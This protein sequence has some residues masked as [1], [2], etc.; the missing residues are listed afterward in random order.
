MFG[1]FLTLD[2]RHQKMFL[3]VGPKRAG[4]GVIAGVLKELVGPE[5]FV[6][7]TL[8]AFGSPFGLE[9]LTKASVACISDARLSSRSDLGQVTENLL[10]I[11][12][13]D[14]S[15]VPRKFRLDWNGVIPARLLMLSNDLPRI[16]D[17]SGAPASRFIVLRMTQSFFGREDKGLAARLRLE[18]PGILNW[19]LVGLDDLNAE[20]WFTEP[21]SS[22]EVM[23]E[24]HD[25]GSPIG[26]FL[27]DECVVNPH[28]STT[29]G[30]LFWRWRDWCDAN[31]RDDKL[32]GDLA[33]FGAKLRS[34]E[35]S[36]VKRRRRLEGG[37]RDYFYD[38]V[39]LKSPQEK[40]E[41]ADDR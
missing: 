32:V 29:T 27:R 9:P 1:Y 20:G 31:H 17:A 19:A 8:A 28:A 14:H 10:K 3:V 23:Q 34:A 12:A 26:A 5:N 7:P 38:G 36:I 18:L 22:R 4:K 37:E 2:H 21:A 33:G 35:P 16:A 13:G 15:T 25:L 24:L 11:S 30:L 41:D 6:S 40:G 39:R